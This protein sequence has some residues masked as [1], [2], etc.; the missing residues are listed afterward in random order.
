VIFINLQL[1][2]FSRNCDNLC[3]IIEKADSINNFLLTFISSVVFSVGK[4]GVFC[5]LSV[6]ITNI[7]DNQLIQRK[8]LF[9]HVVLEISVHFQLFPLFWVC[10]ESVPLFPSSAHPTN[11][12]LLNVPQK[13][14]CWK[15]GSQPEALLEDGRTFRRWGL[16]EVMQ[17]TC[18]WWGYWNSIPFLSLSSFL[19]LHEVSSY[20]SHPLS[21]MM[22]FCL[23][24]A[25]EQ[26]DKVTMS[27]NVWIKI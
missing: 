2:F 5:Y 25:S 18:L 17:R 21:T 23:T 20:P 3:F 10:G 8:G 22:F 27:W 26:W 15:F 24:I 14:M 13:S 7:W 6:T 12:W 1:D 4:S 9:Y 11:I 16:L 19:Q